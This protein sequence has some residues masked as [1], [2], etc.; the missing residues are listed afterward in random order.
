MGVPEI[1]VALR[2]VSETMSEEEL[3]RL[4]PLKPDETW[5][6]GQL[7]QNTKIKEKNNGIQYH[8]KSS[9]GSTLN[10]EVNKL[11]LRLAPAIPAIKALPSICRRHL[12]CAI[13]SSTVPELFLDETVTRILAKCEASIDID[14]YQF[15]RTGSS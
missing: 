3:I 15:D 11:F 8:S 5:S 13:Y 12:A 14:L 10:S 7:R 6:V 9:G 4:L 2:I 1:H